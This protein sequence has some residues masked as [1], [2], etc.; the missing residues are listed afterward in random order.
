MKR[1]TV[2]DLFHGHQTEE[3]DSDWSDVTQNLPEK[4]ACKV[5]VK[6]SDGAV[7]FAY[8]YEDKCNFSPYVRHTSHFWQCVT[9]EELRNVTHWKALKDE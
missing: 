8:F 4:R 2:M 7:T 5:I 1:H 6:T 3:V 9:K